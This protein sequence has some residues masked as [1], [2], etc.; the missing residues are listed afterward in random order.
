M[1][2]SKKGQSQCESYFLSDWSYGMWKLSCI[3]NKPLFTVSQYT[4]TWAITKKII[5]MSINVLILSNRN[6]LKLISVKSRVYEESILAKWLSQL[7]NG[8]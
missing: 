6:N 1:L 3:K 2:H 4:L 5:L 8:W 7:G